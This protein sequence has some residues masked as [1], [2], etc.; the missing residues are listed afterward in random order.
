MVIFLVENHTV[1]YNICLELVEK[2][3]RTVLAYGNVQNT[4]YDLL[5]KGR[6]MV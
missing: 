3:I 1:M 6:G 4:V 5:G 2:I